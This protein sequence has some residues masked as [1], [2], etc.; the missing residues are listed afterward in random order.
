MCII[1]YY[2]NNKSMNHIKVEI[3]VNLVNGPII[4]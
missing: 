3:N 1:Y 4:L 2:D